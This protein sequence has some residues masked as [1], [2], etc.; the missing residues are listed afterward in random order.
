MNSSLESEVL[1]RLEQRIVL[2]EK[3]NN[4]RVKVD[5]SVNDKDE[6]HP[7]FFCARLTLFSITVVIFCASLFTFGPTLWRSTFNHIFLEALYPISLVSW[8]VHE[9]V[10]AGIQTKEVLVE[11]P[12]KRLNVCTLDGLHYIVSALC[13]F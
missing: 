12:N 1:K 8:T 5:T 2:L 10:Y 11:G 3:K 4:I 9:H 6:T 13:F 7:D